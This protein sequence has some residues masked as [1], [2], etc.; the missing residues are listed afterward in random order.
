MVGAR[1]GKPVLFPC[2]LALVVSCAVDAIKEFLIIRHSSSLSLD[3][4]K[5]EAEFQPKAPIAS[6]APVDAAR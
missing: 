4:P 2:K 1:N 6:T 3:L 5:P